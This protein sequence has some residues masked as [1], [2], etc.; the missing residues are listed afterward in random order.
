MFE[1]K[2]TSH[3]AAAHQ[4]TM[5]A[6]KCE[7]L[8]GHNWKIE[9]RVAG[10][11]LN[12]AGVVMDFGEIKQHVSAIMKTFLDRLGFAMHRPRFFG[13]AFTSIV[14]QGVGLGGKIVDYLD[15]AAKCLGFHTV[16]GTCITALET[17][18]YAPPR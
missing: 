17:P 16:K 2:V 13:K 14:T 5:V 10:K 7:N 9:V 4:L 18:P 1:L 12:S 11:E 15:F 6:K 8:H 3:F